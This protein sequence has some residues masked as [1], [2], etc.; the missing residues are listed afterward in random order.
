MQLNIICKA[1]G[2]CTKHNKS[3]EMDNGECFFLDNNIAQI[4]I[5]LTAFTFLNL[6]EEKHNFPL[7]IKIVHHA[8]ILRIPEF[9]LK[10]VKANGKLN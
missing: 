8:Y 10:N 3:I 4:I 2:V 1:I 5:Y 7:E 6:Y 9:L